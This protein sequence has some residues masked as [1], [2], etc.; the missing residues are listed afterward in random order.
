MD[1]WSERYGTH[2]ENFAWTSWLDGYGDPIFGE[3]RHLR[4]TSALTVSFFPPTRKICQDPDRR[5][6][7]D[8]TQDS[9][10][11][12]KVTEAWVPYPELLG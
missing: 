4:S 12:L 10:Q 9:L 11:K 3:D 2:T 8:G 7:H 6:Q 5:H 1:R